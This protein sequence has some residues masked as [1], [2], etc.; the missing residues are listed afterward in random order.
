MKELSNVKIVGGGGGEE[1]PSA[2]SRCLKIILQ[3][4]ASS[5]KL[6]HV[7]ESTYHLLTQIVSTPVVGLFLWIRINWFYNVGPSPAK[8]NLPQTAALSPVALVQRCA[9]STNGSIHK[10]AW[11]TT[12][13]VTQA[14][15][16]TE[17]VCRPFFAIKMTFPSA[18]FVS[19]LSDTFSKQL[20]YGHAC[21]HLSR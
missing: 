10:Q 11:E 5:G 2:K 20:L 4:Q 14:V 13:Q 19:S 12:G 8:S 17:A 15:P 16:G 7:R 21:C 6:C 18:S 1:D 3:L 9:H